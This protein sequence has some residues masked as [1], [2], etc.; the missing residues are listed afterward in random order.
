[1]RR[2]IHIGKILGIPIDIN[3]SWFIIFGLITWTLAMG[4]FPSVLPHE[5]GIVYWLMAIISAVFLFASLLLHELSHSFIAIKNSIPIKGITLFVFGGIAHI[6]EEPKD[7]GT[8]LK[9]AIAG[10][11]CSITISLCFFFLA[12]LL[13]Y[14]GSPLPLIAIAGYIS[15]IN[16]IIAIFNLIPG[17]PLDGGRILRSTLWKYMNDIKKAT[18]IAS[19]IGKGF[20]FFLI[21]VGFLYLFLGALLSGVWLIL[22][23]I[24]LQEAAESSYQQMM[25]QRTLTGTKVHEIMSGNVVTVS[26]DMPLDFVIDNYFFKYRFTSFPV[27]N[28][29]ESLSG[30]VTLH[31]VKD[32]PKQ[33][34]NSTYIREAMIPLNADLI[35]GPDL[36]VFNALRKMIRNKV[37]RLIVVED[38]K[39]V[40]FLSQRDVMRL[41]EVKSDLST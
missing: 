30:L 2:S 14:I 26:E 7:P 5:E 27:I 12:R 6:S 29:A 34:W 37:G 18:R 16:L 25:L 1:L 21:G 20:A 8:E 3:Y 10:P 38:H 4:Y 15:I 17:F 31:N 9:M 39:L 33:K 32:I 11:I 28:S 19:G 36:E 41:F 40:G 24:F 23:G 35:V 13:P 22:I